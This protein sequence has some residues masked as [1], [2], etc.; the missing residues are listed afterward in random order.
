MLLNIKEINNVVYVKN[1]KKFNQIKDSINV[2]KK[3]RD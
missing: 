3:T 1:H 2:E